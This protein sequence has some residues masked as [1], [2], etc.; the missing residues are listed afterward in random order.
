MTTIKQLKSVVSEAAKSTAQG[1]LRSLVGRFQQSDGSIDTHTVVGEKLHVHHKDEANNNT[2][3]DVFSLRNGKLHHESAKGMNRH[4][5]TSSDYH[6]MTPAELSK[7][8]QRHYKKLPSGS[9]V[10]E[11]AHPH[12]MKSM[13][14][15]PAYGKVLVSKSHKEL[16]PD[17]ESHLFNDKPFKGGKVK[18]EES[19]HFNPPDKKETYHMDR[20]GY[21]IPGNVGAI[22]ATKSHF[23][24][25]MGGYGTGNKHPDP[26]HAN[27]LG[28]MVDKHIY[29]M[30]DSGDRQ[31]GSGGVHLIYHKNTDK[32]VGVDLHTGGVYDADDGSKLGQMKHKGDFGAVK[33]AY[34][35]L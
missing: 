4:G 28:R 3:H 15:N 9:T 27:W 22:L 5:T 2:S 12:Y 29:S 8:M 21:N 23:D 11:A 25:A 34:G 6:G 31:T 13:V 32:A 10:S 17:K 7:N 24:D 20:H 26:H 19:R 35:Q 18:G 14:F 30:A 16:D 1:G 33:K